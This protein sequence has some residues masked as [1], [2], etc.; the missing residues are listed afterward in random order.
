MKIKFLGA[1]ET[2]TGSCYQL[3]ST[4]RQTKILIDCGLYQGSPE[5]EKLN[6]VPLECD[7]ANLAGVVLTHAHL[8]HCG[9]LPLLLNWGF[10]KQ[11]WMTP[12]TRDITELS[13]LDSAKINEGED[14]T[15][16]NHKQVQEIVRHFN[17]VEYDHSFS[18]GDFDITLR[19]AGHILGS[20]S[21]EITDR[22]GQPGSNKIIFSGDL[23]NSPQDLINPT[24]PIGPADA[25][26]MESTY[27]DSSHP[28]ENP[29]QI[30]QAEINAVEASGGTLLIPSFSIERSQEL[31]HRISH[32]KKSG[33]VKN[34]TPIFFDSPMAEKVT[35]IFE[36]Y[37]QYFNEEL[38]EDFAHSDPFMF[39]GLTVVDNKEAFETLTQ[40][41]GTKVV[42]AGSGMMTGGRI[43]GQAIR[44]LPLATTRLLIVGYQ[45]EN[46]LG[47]EILDGKRSVTIANVPIEIKASVNQTQAMSSHAD[48]PHLLK[49]LEAIKGVKKIFLTHGENE[50]RQTL[51]EKITTDLH[52]NDISMPK[53]NEEDEFLS[54]AS[55]SSSH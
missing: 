24:E 5:L 36:K 17:T 28:A 1:S 29:S 19:D 9:R 15:L 32:L 33:L 13:L 4:S 48:Q 35:L 26:V 30:I 54:V 37:H 46:T 10:T 43:L 18:L 49:W 40:A 21:I 8:D 2:V 7:C 22:S 34:E 51:S 47:R 45:A 12:P 14:K 38:K 52:I 55:G 11:I 42:I 44:Y 20:A 41:V 23:G 53:L 31:L 16:Y 27:G 25:V 6:Y 50:P 39:P 3:T